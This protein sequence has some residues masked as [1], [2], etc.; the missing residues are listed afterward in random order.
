MPSPTARFFKTA[1]HA[2]AISIYQSL[3]TLPPRAAQSISPQNCAKTPSNIVTTI[4]MAI[5]YTESPPWQAVGGRGRAWYGRSR[6]MGSRWRSLV[7]CW[8]AMSMQSPAIRSIFCL[9][10]SELLTFL[11][12]PRHYPTPITLPCW[13]TTTS[14]QYATQ[15]ALGSLRLLRSG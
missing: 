5:G 2:H 7:A 3:F 1:I 15:N 6:S 9:L 10:P 13:R 12:L 11:P 14:V 8:R 4:A